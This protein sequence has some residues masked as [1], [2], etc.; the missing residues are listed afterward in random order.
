MAELPSTTPDSHSGR[1]GGSLRR[2]LPLVIT[3]FLIAIV[4]A[5]ATASYIAVRRSVS[6]TARGRL[7]TNARQW[8]QILAQGM[9][10]RLEEAKRAAALPILQQRLTA[11]DP[12]TVAAADQQ[13]GTLLRSAPQNMSVELWD[14]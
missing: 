13:L 8:S 7:T 2:R 4:G 6:E 1:R 12:A 10:Q 9:A 14:T 5:G 11:S 3:L